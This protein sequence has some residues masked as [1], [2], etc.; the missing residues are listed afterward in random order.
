MK[1]VFELKPY[2]RCVSKHFWLEVLAFKWLHNVQTLLVLTFLALTYFIC[3]YLWKTR[4][5]NQ[6]TLYIFRCLWLPSIMFSY[7]HTYV[8]SSSLLS[9]WIHKEDYIFNVSTELLYICGR[10]A[11]LL[12]Y[13]AITHQPE[14]TLNLVPVVFECKESVKNC[15]TSFQR[16]Y[17]ANKVKAH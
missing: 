11:C 5:L 8:R 6:L 15:M 9:D 7:I 13:W 10:H 17:T 4:G 2:N 3:I 14:T 1:G 16:L 12:E